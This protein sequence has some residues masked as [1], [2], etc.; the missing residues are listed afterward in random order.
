VT[1]PPEQPEG[2]KTPPPT[3]TVPTQTGVPDAGTP[4]GPPTMTTTTAPMPPTTTVP[5]VQDPPDAG[6]SFMPLPPMFPSADAGQVECDPDARQP[7]CFAPENMFNT[8][9]CDR[10]ERVCRGC[11]NDE[12]C[13]EYKCNENT[14]RCEGCFAYEGRC[15]PGKG[16]VNNVCV[17]GCALNDDCRVGEF[18]FRIAPDR[19]GSCEPC[20]EGNPNCLPCFFDQD[21]RPYGGWCIRGRCDLFQPP[22]PPYAAPPEPQEGMGGNSSSS[23]SSPP[24]DEGMSTMTMPSDQM[25]AG[26]AG[27]ATNSSSAYR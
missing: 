12:E 18:C 20:G 2:T 4:P 25:D 22:L 1:D 11:F 21:C 19:P 5:Q 24:P 23:E 6:G 14:G 8:L 27:S 13:G 17:Q 3:V 9:V 26:A 15:G 16:C 7:V 10:R